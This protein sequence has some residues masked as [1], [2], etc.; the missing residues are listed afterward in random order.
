MVKALQPQ[1]K[2]ANKNI[3]LILY[4]LF[5]FVGSGQNYAYQQAKHNS[6]KQSDYSN[7]EEQRG[8]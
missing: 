5:S 2:N 6:S 1:P 4:N 8:Y 7:Y 3:T